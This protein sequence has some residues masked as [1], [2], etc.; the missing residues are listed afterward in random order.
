MSEKIEIL[1]NQ[2]LSEFGKK[3]FRELEIPPHIVENLSKDLREYQKDALKYYLA[4]NETLKKNHLM[5]NMATGSGKTLI[6][7]ALMLDCFKRGYENFIFFVDKTEIVEKTKANFSDKNSSKY[8]FAQNI[9]IDSKNVEINAISNLDSSK[10]GCINIYFTTIQSLYSLFTNERENCLNLQD[11]KDKK[12]VFLADEAHHLNAETKQG[13]KEEREMQ[14][15]EGV[16]KGAFLSHKDNLMFEFSATIPKFQNVIEKYKDKIIYE[17]EL[18]KFCKNGFSKR[19][20][21]MKYENQNI[22]MRF[23]GGVLMSVFRELVAFKNGIDLKP[24]I[25]FKSENITPSKENHKSFVEF[26]QNLDSK[27]IESF[28]ANLD[29]KNTL[30]ISSLSFFK[31]YFGEYV[32]DKLNSHIKAGFKERFI[33]NANTDNELIKEQKILH[34]LESK[35][36]LVRVIFAVDKL[37]EGW[38]VL[39]LFDIV[40]LGDKKTSN[41]VT[42]K[43]VQLIGRGARYYPF[44]VKNLSDEIAYKRKFDSDLDNELSNLERL[45]YHTIN[46]SKFINELNKSMLAEG[47]IVETKERKITLTPNKKVI[48]KIQN[49]KIYYAKNERVKK[50][51]NL[52]STYDK[53]KI[54]RHLSALKVPLFSND[55]QEEQKFIDEKNSSE[56]LL[57]SKNITKSIDKKYFLK[58]MNMLNI[59]FESLSKKFEYKSKIEFI[60][61]YLGEI[62]LLF[63]KKQKFDNAKDCLDMAIFILKNFNDLKNK[64]Q[65]EYEISDFTCKELDLKERDIFT[66]KEPRDIGRFEW[67]YYHNEMIC[68]STLEYEFLKF[69]ESKKSH[70]DSIFE[71]WFVV[72]NEN[73]NEFKLYDDRKDK[74]SYAMGFEPDFILFAKRR[75]DKGFFGIEC[76]IESKGGHLAQHDSWKEEFLDSINNKSFRDS[77]LQVKSLPFFKGS[78]DTRFNKAFLDI[79]S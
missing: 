78:D 38:D 54:K 44:L 74:D 63:S 22:K 60:E 40:R 61:K 67:L 43:E 10:S 30:F 4:N 3:S 71:K 45:N 52:F 7:A 75:E 13:K 25:L 8:L 47:L 14:G 36:N 1:Q 66:F 65:R 79:E 16:I 23:L 33:I 31:N 20:F 42:T 39:N 68:D 15:W 59:S 41:S 27:S 73:F 69:I 51:N 49:D 9:N 53:D 29:S 17:Y 48:E 56:V 64:I 21:L 18:S 70:L 24:V 6:M 46:D 12:L 35:D 55:I 57:D 19:I 77:K 37:N 5:F 50:E 76:F 26:I 11:L 58:A 34:N 2:V 32:F 62:S 72:R 28:Y